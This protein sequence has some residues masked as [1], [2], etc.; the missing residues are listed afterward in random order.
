MK[1]IIRGAVAA[2]LTIA[3]ALSL[4]GCTALVELL[5]GSE[6][7]KAA[8]SGEAGFVLTVPKGWICS[9]SIAWDGEGF[10]RTVTAT[11][12]NSATDNS[13]ITAATYPTELGAKE[14]FLA[15]YEEEKAHFAEVSEAKLITEKYDLDG[16][17]GVQ[18]E[19]TVK[20]TEE[21]TPASVM[22]IAV[23]CGERMLLITQ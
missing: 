3:L 11:F 5:V 18:Y 2:V 8:N 12:S 17:M 4:C 22:Q 1:K 19:Y 21:S 14:F 15:K 9:E 20:R 23:P 10:T 13:N 6:D 16:Q 7:Y